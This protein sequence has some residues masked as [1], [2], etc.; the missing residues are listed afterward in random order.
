MY[1]YK[2]ELNYED[3]EGFMQNKY[4]ILTH[5]NKFTKE[6]FD[7]LCEGIKSKCSAKWD[8]YYRLI[9][10]LKMEHGFKCINVEENFKIE[11][12]WIK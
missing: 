6:E 2:V 7:E 1:N 9:D 10:T 8:E 3:T 5:N 4:V 12:R 11:Q